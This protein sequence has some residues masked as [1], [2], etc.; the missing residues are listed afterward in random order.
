MSK[1]YTAR[2][3]S[4]P[5]PQHQPRCVLLQ[6]YCHNPRRAKGAPFSA[7]YFTILSQ[8]WNSQDRAGSVSSKKND[9]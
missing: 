8:S 7:A 3:I 9:I 6:L 4:D 1:H 5:P 2:Y